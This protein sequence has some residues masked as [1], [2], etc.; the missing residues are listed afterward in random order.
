MAL[1]SSITEYDLYKVGEVTADP[2]YVDMNQVCEVIKQSRGDFKKF[3]AKKEVHLG[4]LT[5]LVRYVANWC[6]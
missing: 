2:S 3:K 6:S 4:H 5:N 1:L